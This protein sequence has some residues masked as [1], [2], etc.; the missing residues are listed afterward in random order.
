M[1]GTNRGRSISSMTRFSILS[2]ICNHHF[3]DAPTPARNRSRF[4]H[5]T[6]GIPGVQEHA[7]FL[8]ETRDAIKIR[9]RILQCFE[10][11][12]LPSTSD[13]RRKQ[14]LHFCVVGGGPTGVEF[15]AELHDL[16]HDDLSKK[17]PALLANVGIT[18]YDVAP[19]ILSMFDSALAQYATEHFA[20]Q[21]I[22]VRTRR[23]VTRVDNGV[24]HVKEEGEVP[25]GMLVWST[26]VE[27]TPLIKALQGVKKD[28]KG[29]RLVTDG[30][31]RVIQD[32]PPEG[33]P[34]KLIKD[35]YAL[36]DCAVIDGME[37]P[38]TAQVASQKGVWMRK[39]FELLA[40][41]G[42]DKSLPAGQSVDERTTP[43]EV[44]K[45]GKAIIVPEDLEVGT[46]FKFRNYGVL[47]YLGEWKAIGQGQGRWE[48]KGYVDVSSGTAIVLT[49]SLVQMA[50]L[51]PLANRVPH[52]DHLVEE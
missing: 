18:L 38:L 46:P 20:R 45:E 5:T 16:I 39:R 14:L 44:M 12:S 4:A 26:G 35:V 50:S 19:R 42:L 21:H 3:S 15:S 36:G 11:A 28:P 41:R 1:G 22:E 9:R 25:F 34:P 6:F 23:T 40:R 51:V 31:L 37:L 10:E 24:L 30:W 8:K 13:A 52:Y 43:D 33:K 29:G 17:Y 7:Y 32:G 48:L 2:L 27:M 49:F 47:A